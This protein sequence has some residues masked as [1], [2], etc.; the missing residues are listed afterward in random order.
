[1]IGSHQQ[2][3]NFIGSHQTDSSLDGSRVL[4]ELNGNREFGGVLPNHFQRNHSNTGKENN[5]PSKS[6]SY[7]DKENNRHRSSGS[8]SSKP[9]FKINP[10]NSHRLRP[11]RQRTRNAVVSI[12]ENESVVLEFLQKKNGEDLVVEVL[13][14]SN[15][16][17]KVTQFHPHGR[18][19]VLL[20][21]APP[22]IDS[23]SA[24][25]YAFSALPTKL[26]KKYQYAEKFVRLVKM[27]TPKVSRWLFLFYI[28]LPSLNT[29]QLVIPNQAKSIELFD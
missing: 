4:R 22:P 15:D 2:D 9:D 19:G 14:I 7:E 29:G 8:T 26:W 18:Q 16:G 10:L 13:L 25:S 21:D 12:L 28:V 3:S 5:N 27:K 6:Q 24:V 11:I 20:S 23:S 1:M 17:I